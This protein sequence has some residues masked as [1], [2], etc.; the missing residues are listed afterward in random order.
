MTTIRF[1]TEDDLPHLLA[2]LKHAS[3][4]TE[5]LVDA[6]VAFLVADSDGTMAGVIGLQS[7]GTDALLRSLAVAADHRGHGLARRLV[8][9]LETAAR[10][11]G[12]D[13]VYLLTQTAERFFRLQGFDTLPRHEA[14]ATLQSS[15]E[16]RSLCP[17]SATCMRKRLTP[18]IR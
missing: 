15:A 12:I 4:P 1:A 18:S 11:R 14:P 3:L 8:S 9:E 17:A 7:F 6:D 5:D 10:H 13:K 2:L 16:F